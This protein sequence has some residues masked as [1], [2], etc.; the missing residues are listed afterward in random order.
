MKAGKQFF[1]KD[2]R[3]TGIKI[4]A[5]IS[6]TR[7]GEKNKRETGVS[8]LSGHLDDRCSKILETG[9][10]S[11]KDCLID[12]FVEESASE[13]TELHRTVNVQPLKK[14]KLSLIQK[15]SGIFPS[16]LSDNNSKSQGVSLED[17]DIRDTTLVPSVEPHVDD[18]SE[19]MDHDTACVWQ[20]AGRNVTVSESQ[21][22]PEIII[23]GTRSI[24]TNRSAQTKNSWTGKENGCSNDIMPLAK[25]SQALKKYKANPKAKRNHANLSTDIDYTSSLH[26]DT[27]SSSQLPSEQQT[28]LS[29]EKT[30]VSISYLNISAHS[31]LAD[32]II[33]KNRH[34]NPKVKIVPTS[35][36]TETESDEKHPREISVAAESFENT[37]IAKGTI[38]TSDCS[39]T[40]HEVGLMLSEIRKSMSGSRKRKPED[41][42]D[43]FY[44]KTRL[45]TKSEGMGQTDSVHKTRNR[46]SSFNYCLTPNSILRDKSQRHYVPKNKVQTKLS[47]KVRDSSA[48]ETDSFVLTRKLRD[49]L[50]SPLK[51]YSRK[52]HKKIVSSTEDI[53][54]PELSMTKHKSPAKTSGESE[55][56]RYFLRTNC[57]HRLLTTDTICPSC[58]HT[59][60]G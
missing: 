36:I 13:Q 58:S 48:M 3:E 8:I 54:I 22:T 1:E 33:N 5:Y 51:T 7:D 38:N 18:G 23:D 34:P 17:Q 37:E 11:N 31:S 16:L 60:K 49:N 27:P 30:K 26:K 41:N 45:R 24:V 43:T 20:G 15:D 55:K 40:E 10:E 28:V 12:S 42:T 47:I 19:I 52:D 6:S 57:S 56:G 32:Q 46:K 44:V 21:V 2:Q 9:T 39:N 14:K 25:E 50:G 35:K 53:S 29:N 4:D 59:T